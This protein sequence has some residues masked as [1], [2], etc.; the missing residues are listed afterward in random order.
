MTLPFALAGPSL[1]WYLTRATGFVAL[2]LLTAS[3]VLGI[4]GP[5]RVS[6][7]PRWPRFAIETVHRDVSL[8]VLVVLAI[9]IITTALDTFTSISLT[10]GVIPF[11]SNYRP[12]WLGLGTV[13]FDLLIALVVTSLVRRRLGYR[14]WRAIHWLAYASWPIAVLHGLGTGSDAKS[15]WGVG[16]TAACAAAVLLAVW[17]RI[18]AAADERVR[19]PAL[20][21]SVVVPIGIAVFAFAGPL[22]RGWAASAGTPTKLLAPA[23]VASTKPALSPVTGRGKKSTATTL[24]VPFSA[25]L[26]GTVAQTNV[27][28]GAVVDLALRLSGGAHGRLRIRLGGTPI[29]GGGLSMTGSQVVLQAVGLP[30][31]MEGQVSSLVGQKFVAHVTGAGEAALVLRAQL[32]IDNGNGAVSGLLS[33]S[34]ASGGGG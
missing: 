20:G 15:W 3:V 14:T 8:L 10:A 21:A 19:V 6:A 1:Y 26:A 9:H 23:R 11:I 18:G 34:P 13:S 7:P 27:A 17:A 31:V 22:Q 33:A 28:D 2:V 12:L 29:G 5:L 25:R 24:R 30:S 4:L 16:L 32:T